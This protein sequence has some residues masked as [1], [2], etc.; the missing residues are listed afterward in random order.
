[1]TQ[2]P[3]YREIG[4]HSFC[5]DYSKPTECTPFLRDCKLYSLIEKAEQDCTS[6]E[7]KR[8]DLYSLTV[9][10]IQDGC[11]S[12]FYGYLEGT[13]NVREIGTNVYMFYTFDT[14]VD[15]IA[16]R[17]R[18]L[19]S[20]HKL[21]NEISIT[22]NKSGIAILPLNKVVKKNK[23]LYYAHIKY[24]VISLLNDKPVT[25]GKQSIIRC[26][27]KLGLLKDIFIILKESG[28]NSPA[29]LAR[30]FKCSSRTIGRYKEKCS[31]L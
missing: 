15:Y 27:Y 10:D 29:R 30:L 21:N 19:I 7:R 31:T 4:C 25:T 28:Y 3:F 23:E 22:V 8:R 13:V 1:M 12:L 5:Q 24:L 20:F 14:K 18:E 9:K 17:Q 11:Y 26:Y 6:L 16:N 2:C